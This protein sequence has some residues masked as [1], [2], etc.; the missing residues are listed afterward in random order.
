MIFEGRHASHA[1]THVREI[2]DCFS[3]AWIGGRWN[4]RR[5]FFDRLKW[6]SP[7]NVPDLGSLSRGHACLTNVIIKSYYS[8]SRL[9]EEA[10]LCKGTR[11]ACRLWKKNGIWER[12]YVRLSARKYLFKWTCH[13]IYKITTEKWNLPNGKNTNHHTCLFFKLFI[14]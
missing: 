13:N 11:Q 10:D 3:N 8:A 5:V 1:C 9:F 2:S 4:Y 7:S 14:S 12:I 6:K